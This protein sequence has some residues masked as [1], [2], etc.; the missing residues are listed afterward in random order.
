MVQKF[1][2]RPVL[3]TVISIL[4]CI[5]G[6][7]GYINLPV[8]QFPNIAPPMVRVSAS[9]PGANAQTVLRSVGNTIG[10]TD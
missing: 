4:I 6:I 10:R 1:L 8:E 7:L 5:L 3:S 2:S 9:F